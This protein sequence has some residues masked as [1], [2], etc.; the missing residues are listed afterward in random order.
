MQVGEV[1]FGTKNDGT[2]YV[3]VSE[4]GS[5]F[6]CG[7]T[8]L[9]QSEARELGTALLHFAEHGTLPVDAG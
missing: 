6:D 9:S 3:C 5:Y 7:V 2:M 4:G 1:E 8:S